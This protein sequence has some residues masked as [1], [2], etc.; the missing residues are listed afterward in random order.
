MIQVA[1]AMDLFEL[2]CRKNHQALKHSLMDKVEG[3]VVFERQSLSKR[4]IGAMLSCFV[5]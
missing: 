4:L 3:C 2:D 5:F 1:V